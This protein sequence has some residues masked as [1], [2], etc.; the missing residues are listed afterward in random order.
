MIS[1]VTFNVRGMR[2]KKKRRTIFRHLHVN[3]PNSIISLQETHSS[4]ADEKYWST[5]WGGNI[6]YSHCQE[7]AGG[8]AFLFPR[9]NDFEVKMLHSSDE[10]RML[11]LEISSDTCNVILIGVYAPSAS[12]QK[13]KCIF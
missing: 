5:E 13:D 2:T 9:N 7:N 8:V 6:Y 4:A 10:G 12:R 11:V 3:Y 1:I